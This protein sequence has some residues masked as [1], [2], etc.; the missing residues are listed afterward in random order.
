MTSA[1][2]APK[3]KDAECF[4][5]T[6]FQRY[7]G[8]L[9]MIGASLLFFFLALLT[10]PMVLLA[11]AKFATSYTFGSLLFLLSFTLLN[12]W[13]AHGKHLLSWERAP[14]T[15]TYVGSMLLCLYFSLI[16]PSYLAVIFFTIVEM[17][18]LVWY[19][20]SY[21][22]GGTGVMTRLARSALPV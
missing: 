3:N 9:M 6:T 11:P 19:G 8:F 21:F 22:P 1:A 17:G 16:S 15:I 20:A 5:L 7:I 18:A 2:S 13:R 12:G 14:F 4:G 10:L